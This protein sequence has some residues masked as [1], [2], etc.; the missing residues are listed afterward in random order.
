V[1]ES[2]RIKDQLIKSLYF[3]AADGMKIGTKISVGEESPI[4]IG[5]DYHLKYSLGSNIH[6]VELQPGRA[7]NLRPFQPGASIR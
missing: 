5:N 2:L 1:Q 7:H 6:S 4:E 3:G